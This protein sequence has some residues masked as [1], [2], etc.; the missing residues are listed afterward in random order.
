[1]SNSIKETEK[2][3]YALEQKMQNYGEALGVL[4]WD[5]R[6]GAPKKG[7]E[8][9]SEVI[10][11]LSQ[12]IFAMSTSNEMKTYLEALTDPSVQ[13]ELGDVTKRSVEVAK[14]T[15]D[16]NEKIPA[17]EYKEYVILQSKAETVWTDAKEASDFSMLQP[18][19]EKLVDFKQRFI[20]YW[21]HKGTKYDAL[22][23]Q[24]EPGVTVETIDR[25]FDEVQKAIVPL[26]EEISKARQPKTDFLFHHFPKEKQRDF[27]LFMLNEIGYDLEA[28]RLDETAHPF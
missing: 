28:G 12:E 14:K 4:G 2:A 13:S 16:L 23:D 25:V 26:V 27:S 6:T 3:Y 7:V 11:T 5:L 8:Q 10:G 20:N 1:M 15:Y 22:L 21:G 19:L 24:Y 9:R 18:Y 17:E